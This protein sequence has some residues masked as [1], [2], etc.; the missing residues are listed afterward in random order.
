MSKGKKVETLEDVDRL[1]TSENKYSSGGLPVCRLCGEVHGDMASH[2]KEAHR[3]SKERYKEEYPGW[4]LEPRED[5]AFGS[6]GFRDRAVV[7]YSVKDTFGF[8]WNPKSKVDKKVEGFEEAGPLTPKIDPNYVFSPEYTSVALLGLN[9][10]DKVLTYGPTGCHAKGTEIRMHDGSIKRVED[11][12]VGDQLMGPDKGPRSVLS[13]K[14]GYGDM[15][16]VS[17]GEE[18]FVV[19]SDHILTLFKATHVNS[20]PSFVPKGGSFESVDFIGDE[21]GIGVDSWVD[22]SVRE[23]RELPEAEL[24]KYFAISL[25]ENPGYFSFTMRDVGEDHFYGFGLDR[26]RRYL[27]GNGIVTH[28][29]GKTSFWEQIAARLNYN[30][31]RINFDAGITRADL[32]GQWVVKGKDMTFAYGILPSAMV[33]PGTI[34]CLDEWDTISEECSFVLQRPLEQHS[35]LLILEHG[36]QVITLHKHNMI[37]GTANTAGMGD[38]TG[39]YSAG[40]RLQN[41]SQINRFSMTIEMDYLPAKEEQKILARRFPELEELMVEAMVQV[42]NSVRES[43][44]QGEI[45]APLS[46]RDVINW[47]EK[48]TFWGDIEKASKYCFINRMPPEDREVM[49]QIVFRAFS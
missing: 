36:E 18:T 26:D 34:I 14:R 40:T 23:L 2:I 46:T 15:V 1:I 38:D 6:L 3:F 28:N 10:K 12:E 7:P 9:L 30:F 45:S 49:R 25:G 41:F 44:M 19:N 42:A 17:V 31:I 27:M 24:T 32:V 33:L 35:Q 11:V 22:I 4:P 16:E 39:L 48:F 47:A 37:V 8:Y 13:L 20:V 43:F 29:S 21:V 5:S